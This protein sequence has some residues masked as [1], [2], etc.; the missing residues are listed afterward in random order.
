MNSFEKNTLCKD[1]KKIKRLNFYTSKNNIKVEDVVAQKDEKKFAL[2][3]HQ[4][5]T[6]EMQDNLKETQNRLILVEKNSILDLKKF[7]CAKCGF[8]KTKLSELKQHLLQHNDLRP[9]ICYICAISFK[10]KGNLSKHVKT[11]AHLDKCVQIGMNPD[12]AQI[13]QVSIHNVDHNILKKQ[14]VMDKS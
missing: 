1:D 6:S 10:T 4:Q 8:K 9:F 3:K 13:R 5:N 12:D 2:L 14:M 11:K 7:V